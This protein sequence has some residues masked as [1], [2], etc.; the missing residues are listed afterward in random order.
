MRRT[1]ITVLSLAGLVLALVLLC[2][3]GAAAVRA[4][5][6][7][8]PDI[9]MNIGTARLIARTSVIPYCSQLIGPDCLV[10]E[11]TPAARIYT[12]WL[13]IRTTP[14]S[15][16]NAHIQRLLTLQIRSEGSGS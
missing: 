9:D 8:P 16:E 11:R 4:G 14:G 2:G 7:T 15:W 13:F 10:G 3:L 6:M 12:A 1:H 5:T